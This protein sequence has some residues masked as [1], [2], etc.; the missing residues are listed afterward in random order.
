MPLLF[1]DSRREI[2]EPP[3]G[4]HCIALTTEQYMELP[5]VN[6]HQSTL[7]DDIE[8]VVAELVA[9]KEEVDAARRLLSADERQR[10]DRFVFERDRVSFTLARAELR[11]LLGTRLDTR[12]EHVEFD[13]GPRGKPELAHRFKQS[14]LR[15]NL[16]HSDEVAVYAICTGREVGADVE[17]IREISDRDDLVAHCFS[18]REIQMYQDL[19][20]GQKTAGF[21]RCWTRKEA[22][23]KALGDGLQYPLTNFDVTL[24]PDDAANFLRIG[25]RVGPDC[26]WDLCSITPRPGFIGAI[27]V[28]SST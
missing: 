27:A 19:E 25:E 12:A 18:E 6:N 10:A 20:E 14:N 8:I 28:Q 24:W 22:F 2:G 23:V 1:R 15:F 9:S 7:G 16:S 17:A 4:P 21:Y 13:Y 5:R 3:G 26:G 11:R